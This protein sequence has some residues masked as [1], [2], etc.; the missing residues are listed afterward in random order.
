M[1]NKVPDVDLVADVI[2]E[3]SGLWAGRIRVIRNGELIETWM[4]P[5]RTDRKEAEALVRVAMEDAR[6]AK[7]EYMRSLN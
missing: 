5:G 2:R 3:T 7:A 1:S 6:R 4:I